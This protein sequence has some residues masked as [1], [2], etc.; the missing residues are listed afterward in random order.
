MSIL[1]L[2]LASGVEVT[3]HKG[4]KYVIE[5]PIRQGA[6]G[7]VY[8]AR[9]KVAHD[10]VGL[11]TLPS[12][13]R[14]TAVA[15]KF[16]L[17]VFRGVADLFRAEGKERLERLLDW[18]GRE[19]NCLRMIDH[20]N[21][22]SILDD[23]VFVP[24]DNQLDPDLR[25]YG[26]VCFIVTAFIDGDN[27]TDKLKK[28]LATTT[29]VEI[30][31][32]VCDGL[33]YLHE[34]RQYL[35]ADIRS[36]NIVVDKLTNRAVIVDF[37]LFKNF[38]PSETVGTG[39][40]RVTADP[41]ILPPEVPIQ[42]E[43]LVRGDRQS[44]KA[45]WFPRLDLCELGV[46]FRDI[47]S[48]QAGSLAA[49]EHNYLSV[50]GEELRIWPKLKDK[51]ARW[52]REQINK[53]DPAYSRFMGVEE[54]KPPSSTS[55]YLQ[56][57]GRQITISALVSRILE[58]RS[59]R[60][61]S[62]INQLGMVD[63]I[64]PG[65]GHRRYMHCLRAYGYCC[66]FLMA[67]NNSPH[68]RMYFTPQL[69]RQTLVLALLHDINHFP[70]LHTFQELNWPSFTEISLLDLT[71]DGVA[72]GD[73]PSLYEI[74]QS[75]TGLEPRQLKDI[76]FGKFPILVERNYPP[77]LQIAKSLIDSGADIDKLAYLEDDSAHTGVAYGRGIDVARL[78]AS[79]TVT[80]VNAGLQKGWHVAF[81]ED[82]VAA[83]ESLVMARY[84][85]F[86]SVYWH[87]MN[88]AFMAMLLEVARAVFPEE[89]EP[90]RQL[91][92][93][94]N[95]V[96]V[97]DPNNPI[98][99]FIV[100]TMW[101][102][103]DSALDLLNARYRDKFGND[104][105]IADLV[106][107]PARLY[108]RICSLLGTTEMPQSEMRIHEELQVYS[109]KQVR[110]YREKLIAGLNK[111]KVLNFPRQ[112]ALED[113][114]LDIPGRRL[115][116]SGPIYIVREWGEAQLLSGMEGPVKHVLSEFSGLAKRI[117]VFVSPRCDPG[118]AALSREFREQMIEEMYRSLL[119]SKTN[120]VS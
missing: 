73:N 10:G 24:A 26:S 107:Q 45:Y 50:L 97:G 74:V 56:I 7:V 81:K 99:Q 41:S 75:E 77:G 34:G 22:V 65:A 78:I 32:D 83:V 82:G 37:G 1:P 49:D 98:R 103:E 88:R 36:D 31:K 89:H 69:A 114:L 115:D 80:H 3:G 84:W 92:L 23:G 54:L 106:K 13:F 104:S 8:R 105:I 16:F 2:T 12:P 100:Q 35:H 93:F 61:L 101:K 48:A 53:L 63:L 87:R 5:A 9:L 72:T 112:M 59:F 57:P 4:F 70:F 30:L 18:H 17:P 109:N 21:I 111:N 52:V 33:I 55:R 110:E 11:P 20:P 94:E 28:P 60:R 68:F 19:L 15:V 40:T 6:S 38:N 120:E 76:L 113:L 29:L 90:E 86:R 46:L 96:S 42:E 51:S 118:E 85:M 62:F 71:C 47:C 108:R 91:A 116:P 39:I 64:Y 43:G 58:T 102:S 44:L 67:L 95:P 119:P 14:S 27:L 117:R 25:P 66:D 79:A